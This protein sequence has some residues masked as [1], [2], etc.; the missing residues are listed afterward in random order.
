MNRLS[1]TWVV[2]AASMTA[3]IAFPN[4]LTAGEPG[5]GAWQLPCD[6]FGW[7]KGTPV[8]LSPHGCDRCGCSHGKPMCIERVP[9]KEYVTGKKKLFHTS[10]RYEYV[11]IP[12]TRYRWKKKWIT[13]EVPCDFCKPVCDDDKVDHCFGVERWDKYDLGCGK[14]HCKT[15]E[16]TIEK[17]PTK[18]CKS[19]PGKTTVKVHYWSCVK[20]PYTVYRRVKRPICVKQPYYVDVK[21]PITRYECKHCNGAGCDNCCP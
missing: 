11:S 9:V 18:H 19:E 21:V 2:F 8:D 3:F 14:L 13:K 20:E 4:A 12:E 17:L 6:L 16:P 7:L 5:H 10:I 15:I 1:K